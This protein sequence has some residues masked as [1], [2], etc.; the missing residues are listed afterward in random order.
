MVVNLLLCSHLESQTPSSFWVC[1]SLNLEQYTFK[2]LRGKETVWAW[3]ACASEPGLT[4]LPLWPII[5]MAA[6]TG[7]QLMGLCK[8]VMTGK[9]IGADFCYSG[10]LML[11][12]CLIDSTC[13]CFS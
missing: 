4:G 2:G 3:V 1:A 7:K 8:P 9:G 6:V 13:Y 11:I 10:S 12:S 5:H